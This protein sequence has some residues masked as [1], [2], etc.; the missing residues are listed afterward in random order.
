MSFIITFN[1]LFGNDIVAMQ[2]LSYWMLDVVIHCVLPTK[3]KTSK[4]VDF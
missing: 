4:A 2:S 3:V 1:M